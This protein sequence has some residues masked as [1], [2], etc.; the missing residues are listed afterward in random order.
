MT[1]VFRLFLA[2]TTFEKR[3]RKR[4]EAALA[5][6]P[7]NHTDHCIRSFPNPAR[8]EPRIKGEQPFPVCGDRRR[9]A[10]IYFLETDS[11]A[12]FSQSVLS[13]A[14]E[15]SASQNATSLAI[16]NR[17]RRAGSQVAVLVRTL[18]CADL[19]SA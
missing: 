5:L 19:K 3:I 7:Y 18:V 2:P 14:V 6:T 13:A 11:Y 12:P 9:Q 8:Y 17:L 15:H 4:I 16:G 10:M 1:G